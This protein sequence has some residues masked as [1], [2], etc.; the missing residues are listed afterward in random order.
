MKTFATV[1]R[2][3]SLNEYLCLAQTLYTLW[4]SVHF[5]I[6]FLKV[7]VNAAC[8]FSLLSGFNQSFNDLIAFLQHCHVLKHARTYYYI[9][10]QRFQ[11][12]TTKTYTQL[13]ALESMI[14][15]TY[16]PPFEAPASHGQSRAHEP[17]GER[18]F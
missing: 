13:A 14:P 18:R 9:V 6:Q 17:M 4:F 7:T 8:T 12:N 15:S 10:W 2:G 5:I 11:C 1:L 3:R 16:Q